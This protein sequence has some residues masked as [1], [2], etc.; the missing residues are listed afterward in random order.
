MSF[1]DLLKIK[2]KDCKESLEK[3]SE[4]EFV[5]DPRYFDMGHSNSNDIY[6]R[7]G[8]VNKLREINKSIYPL[9]LKIWD[10]YRSRE[11]QESIYLDYY[12]K[13][14]KEYKNWNNEKIIIEVEKFVAPYKKPFIPNHL[15]GGSVDLTLVDKNNEEL[16][17]GT[18]FDEFS[19]RSF[20]DFFKDENKKI[21]QN[22]IFLRDIMTGFGFTSFYNEWWHFDYGNQNWAK[23]LN[24]NIAI[25]DDASLL[26]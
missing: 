26:V 4:S 12:N 23:T 3:L 9:Q 20:F 24:K 21:H 13:L 15:T 7:K 2:V 6:L 8:V 16:E 11:V 1:K 25:Y 5:L 14:E 18:K 22:R 10:G 17:M 19:S